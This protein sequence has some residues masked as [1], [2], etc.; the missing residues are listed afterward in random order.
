MTAQE[1]ASRPVHEL[2]P[3]RPRVLSL[4]TLCAMLLTPLTASAQDE[5]AGSVDRSQPE[6]TAELAVSSDPAAG[7]DLDAAELVPSEDCLPRRSSPVRW[8]AVCPEVFGSAAGRSDNQKHR[9]ASITDLHQGEYCIN[10]VHSAGWENP[11][12]VTFGSLELV[13]TLHAEGCPDLALVELMPAQAEDEIGC[14]P[15]LYALRTDDTIGG[16]T[17]VL[18]VLNQVLLVETGDELRYLKSAGAQQPTWRLTWQSS[19]RFKVPRDYSGASK[20]KSKKKKKKKKKKPRKA[21]KRK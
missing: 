7:A 10:L 5:D 6:E 19:W 9:E 1:G 21:K 17:R 2:N 18:G 20:S 3:T 8:G 13:E 11:A 4:L 16:N 12:P 14:E 15:G